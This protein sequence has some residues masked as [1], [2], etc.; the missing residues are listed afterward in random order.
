M[1]TEKQVASAEQEQF[2]RMV[3]ETHQGS[4]LTIKQFCK[5]EG[6]SEAAFYAWRKKL[7]ADHA[8]ASPTKPPSASGA[9]VEVALRDA[10][11]AA[12]EL[13]LSSG[14]RLRISPNIDAALLERVL[15]TLKRAGL[16]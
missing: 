13:V 11:G 10:P 9:F 3:F 5:N 12:L 2:W 8:S 6:I 4:G 15:A 1:G 16:C 14:H 7:T